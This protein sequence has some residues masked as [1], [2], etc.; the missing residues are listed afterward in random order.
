M[1]LSLEEHPSAVMNLK[2][3]K[4]TLR[5]TKSF[6]ISR[7]SRPSPIHLM[8]PQTTPSVRPCLNSS[9][10][11]RFPNLIIFFEPCPPPTLLQPYNVSVHPLSIAHATSQELTISQP[12][13]IYPRPQSSGDF[14]LIK[15]KED[16]VSRASTRMTHG[17]LHIQHTADPF[18]LSLL[19]SKNGSSPNYPSTTSLLFTH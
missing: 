5:S 9:L 7:L 18:H 1:G 11:A 13:S 14:S 12:R 10:C 6:K 4:P 19:K 8:Y 17:A 3:G 2:P 15:V 16:V